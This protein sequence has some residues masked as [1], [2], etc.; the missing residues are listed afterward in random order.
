MHSSFHD[1]AA[2]ARFDEAKLQKVNLFEP[3]RMFCDV[4]CLLPGQTQKVHAHEGSD[5]IYHVL[6]GRAQVSIGDEV[7]EVGP[8]ITAVAPADVE[9]GICNVGDEPCTVLVV[10]APHPS[11]VAR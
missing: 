10:M 6:T 4:Y 7:R 3:P 5:K 1:T 9:H 11:F 8:G 2:V